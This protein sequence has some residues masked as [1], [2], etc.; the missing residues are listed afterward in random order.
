MRQGTIY[1][2]SAAIVI[3]D[4]RIAALGQLGSLGHP[5][6]RRTNRPDRIHGAPV[7]IMIMKE[8]GGIR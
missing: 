8:H 5:R 4:G 3:S 2:A 6:K 1:A 7:D